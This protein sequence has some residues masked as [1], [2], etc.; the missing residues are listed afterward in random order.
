MLHNVPMAVNYSSESKTIFNAIDDYRQN[1]EGYVN[2]VS[3]LRSLY[4]M[5]AAF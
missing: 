4:T 2:V 5:D 3:K 1:S